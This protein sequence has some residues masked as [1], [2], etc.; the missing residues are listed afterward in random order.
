MKAIRPNKR[1]GNPGPARD[2]HVVTNGAQLRWADSMVRKILDIPAWSVPEYKPPIPTHICSRCH[3][4]YAAAT[5]DKPYCSVCGLPADKN[6]RIINPPA[7]DT[8]VQPP[9]AK[10]GWLKKVR[11]F[12]PS[13][14]ALDTSAQPAH[15]S[16]SRQRSLYGLLPEPPQQ[17][18]EP[19]R[20]RRRAR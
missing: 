19:L 3:T 9:L 14:Q 10:R 17:P 7:P 6:D 16:S 1:V 2:Y 5:P 15:P 13:L 4:R 8:F 11:L 20:P 18:Q 12:N